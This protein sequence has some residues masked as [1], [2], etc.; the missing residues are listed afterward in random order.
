MIAMAP[1]DYDPRKDP[2][3]FSDAQPVSL[4]IDAV[5][6]Y[7]QKH[8]VKTVGYIGFADGFGDQVYEATKQSAAKAG[9]KLVADERYA[10]TDTSV[11]AQVL[12]LIS[13]HPDAVV[14][15]NSATPAALPVIGLR[16]HGYKGLITGNHGIVSPAII[17]V[18]GSSAEG[19]IA[20]TGPV[21]VYNQLPANNPVQPVANSF[22]SAYVKLFGADSV[23]PFAGYS[24]DAMLL[25]R[26]AIPMALEKGQPGTPAFREALRDAL[27]QTKELVGTHGVYTMS[28]TDHNGQ[29]QRAAVLVQIQNGEWKLIH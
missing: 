26:H 16:R 22:M 25:L 6:G 29:D 8:G 5:F 9:M 23:N 28:P 17:R 14:M 13:N 1:L 21:V 11:D 27:E 7:L 24:Y 12:K 18:G 15:G 19:V 3:T 4:I 20:A 2:D 10:R